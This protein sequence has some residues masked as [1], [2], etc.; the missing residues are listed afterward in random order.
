MSAIIL[1]G[2][3]WGDEGKGKV[4]DFLAEK[5]EV[6]VR[7]Q[8][9][10]NAGH[11][12]INGDE[13]YKLHLIPSGILNPNSLNLIGN[14]VVID[15]AVILDEIDHLKARGVSFEHFYISDR[16][17]LIMPY[18][19]ILD[20]LEE[21]AKAD[22]KIG[23]TGRGIGPAYVDKVNRIGIRV[24]D[25]MD[26]KEFR[27]KLNIALTMKNTLLEKVYG[28][29]PL[30]LE[31][32]VEDFM[33]LAE[34]VR[35]FV[36]DTSVLLYDA[37]KS[38]KKVLF[39]G[40]QATHLDID[41]GTYPFVTSSNPIAGGALTGSGVGPTWIDK[42]IGVSKSYTTRVGNGPFP[43]ELEDEM[44]ETLRQ[45]GHEFGTT[46]GRPRR[47][48]WLDAVVVRY[49]VRVNGITDIALT[50]L[51][52][53]D[54]LKEI[55]LCVAYQCGDEVLK[56][57]PAALNQIEKCTPIYETMPG[58]MCDTSACRS[59]GELPQAAKDYIARIEEL[60]DAKVSIIA[61]GP[62]RKQTIVRDEF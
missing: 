24:C 6:V 56:E 31:T 23:T 28:T 9:G 39:E 4:T 20:A 40:A 5:S 21:Q 27:R 25:L 10:N 43:T 49:S 13:E 34:R 16:A 17:H 7:S 33:A 52:V 50:K 55:K 18:H 58:W 46:T 57:F 45:K 19:K 59:F 54:E 44:G 47:C 53:L 60:T 35:P 11:T 22:G 30:D 61:V 38:D 2:A 8:G 14:G 37:L 62:D 3:Q 1:I 26:E 15:L 12:V 36:A 42:V 48:G 51:D 41:H 29:E 32:I